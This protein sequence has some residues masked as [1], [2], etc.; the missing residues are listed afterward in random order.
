[1]SATKTTTLGLSAVLRALMIVLLIALVV[2]ALAMA[3]DSPGAVLDPPTVESTAPDQ[4]PTEATSPDAP[5]PAAD[6]GSTATE[7]PAPPVEE[8]PVDQSP[9]YEPTPEPT[10]PPATTIPGPPVVVVD[11]APVEPPAEVVPVPPVVTLPVVDAIVTTLPELVATPATPPDDAAAKLLPVVVIPAAVADAVPTSRAI[12]LPAAAG[13]VTPTTLSL[14]LATGTD[15]PSPLAGDSLGAAPAKPSAA[16]RAG[17]L[18]SNAALPQDIFS[19]DPNHNRPVAGVASTIEPAKGMPLAGRI[20]EPT[21]F[22]ETAVAAVGG[23]QS[24]SSLLS[25]LAGY[26]LPGVGGPPATTIIMFMLVG[27]IVGLA[28]APRPQLSERLH[29]GGLLAARSGHGLAVCRPG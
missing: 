28:R 26:V 3:D 16:T 4:P 2:P 5:P 11:P 23:I 6:S 8:Q 25:V 15:T 19:L 17:I 24:G 7:D 9:V 21:L 29:L 18:T 27:L 13:P 22:A 10:T 12:A 14:K 1:M 20:A